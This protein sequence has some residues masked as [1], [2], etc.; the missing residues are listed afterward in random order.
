MVA[1]SPD[2]ITNIA[3]GSVMVLIGLVGIWIVKWSTD[4]MVLA[5]QQNAGSSSIVPT[6]SV[7]ALTN[8]QS[9]TRKA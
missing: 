6:P 1:M 2:L 8:E 7:P 5:A 4:R 9:Q 3:F